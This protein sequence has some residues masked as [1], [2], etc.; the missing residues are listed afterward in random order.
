MIVPILVLIF[1]S[2]LG[3]MYTGGFFEGVDF[4]TAVGENPVGGLCIGATVACALPAPC[5]YPR[6]LTHAERFLW[7]A[8][9]RACA[10]WSAAIMILVAGMELGRLLPLHA[11]HGRLREQL[12]N[13]WV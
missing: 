4:A 5:S 6:G 7:R 9:P 11:R 2:I 12:L 1:F 13:S 8:S 10:P 3:M